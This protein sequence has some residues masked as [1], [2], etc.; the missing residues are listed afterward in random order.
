[1]KHREA[2]HIV[3][4]YWIL[5]IWSFVLVFKVM[6]DK[7]EVNSRNKLRVKKLKLSTI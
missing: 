3:N 6:K 5:L 7:E 4:L 1:M 2:T